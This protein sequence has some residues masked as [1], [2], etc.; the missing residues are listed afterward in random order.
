MERICSR[1]KQCLPITS[2]YRKGKSNFQS[3]CKTCKLETLPKDRSAKWRKKYPH[4]HAA[5][6]SLRRSKR[7]SA[8]PSWDKELTLFLIEEA[9]H[10]R[11]MRDSLTNIKWHVDHIIPLQGKFVT[12]LHVWN[13]IEVIPAKENLKKGNSYNG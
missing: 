11:G 13:N 6:Q 9:H 2:F 8:M 4:K 5:T 1:C 7:V 10:L 12:G 3:W